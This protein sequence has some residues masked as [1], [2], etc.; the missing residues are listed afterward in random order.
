MMGLPTFRALDR[1]VLTAFS[2]Y[3]MEQLYRCD[4]VTRSSFVLTGVYYEK[5]TMAI[6][7]ER[8]YQVLHYYIN[9]VT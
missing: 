2:L 5:M 9:E 4:L 7:E 8:L 3:L 6:R 1:L